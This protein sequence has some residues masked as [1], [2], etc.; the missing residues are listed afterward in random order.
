M[1]PVEC[2]TKVAATPKIIWET[3][4]APMKW[5][6]W[7]PDM[8]KMV[9]VNGDGVNDGTE[10]KFYMKD[11]KKIKISLA[12]CIKYQSVYFSGKYGTCMPA[13]SKIQIIPIEDSE[14]IQTEIVYSFELNGCVGSC[15]TAMYEPMLVNGTEV[16]LCNI[17]KL[18]E[19][20]QKES[21]KTTEN[22]AKGQQ[23]RRTSS[24]KV[25][26]ISSSHV[27]KE[28]PPNK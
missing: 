16:G 12:N 9:N 24:S 18:S 21:L 2:K 26:R 10:V 5:E 28:Q 4:F 15:V 6:L 13:T 8:E 3:C 22:G 19:K 20:A 11:G 23:Q 17:K 25:K 1:A 27:R 14:K 7:D